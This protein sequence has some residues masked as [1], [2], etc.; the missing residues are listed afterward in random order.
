M[1]RSTT[2][3]VPGEFLLM[4]LSASAVVLKTDLYFSA[5][6]CIVRCPNHDL[7]AIGSNKGALESKS[8]ELMSD[9]SGVFRELGSVAIGRGS[10]NKFDLERA[11]IRTG[12]LARFVFFDELRS[13]TDESHWLC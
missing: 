6:V 13:W 11:W 7:C 3:P 2:E 8:A 5:R 4:Q 10:I 12:E 1:R 9:E